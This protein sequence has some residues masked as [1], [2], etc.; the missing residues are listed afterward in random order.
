MKLIDTRASEYF[1]LHEDCK[2]CKYSLRCY[3]GCRADALGVDENNIMGKAPG[4]CELF[5][6]GWVEKIIDVVKKFRPNAKSPVLD[7]ELWKK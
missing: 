2:K 7:D 6:G 1:A 3:G 4:S 5:R